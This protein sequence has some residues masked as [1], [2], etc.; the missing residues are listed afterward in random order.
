MAARRPDTAVL[1]VHSFTPCLKG[2]APRP[3]QVG[4]LYSER[5]TRL[6]R[7]LVERLRR[8]PDLCIGDNEPYHGD[9][10][11]DSIDRHALRPGRLNVLVELRNDLIGTAEEQAAWADRLVPHLEA[12]LAEA[13]IVGAID[14]PH[15]ETRHG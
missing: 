14:T 4:I 3:W 5:D 11:G 12:A 8:E 6:A 9:L 13:D 1:A 2:R 7:P 15:Q 10:P